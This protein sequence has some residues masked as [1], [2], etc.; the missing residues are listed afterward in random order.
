[1]ESLRREFADSFKSASKA[2][3]SSENF[4]LQPAPEATFR[5]LTEAGVPSSAITVVV[6]IR[7]QDEAHLAWYN[8][9][10]KAQGYTGSLEDSIGETLDLWD[11][12]RQL[13]PWADTFGAE[14]LVV[15][16]FN[17]PSL[18][19]GDIRHDFLELLGL[20]SN[21]FAFDQKPMNTGLNADLLAFQRELNR[22]PLS[23]QEKRLFHKDL[24]ELSGLTSGTGLFNDLPLLTAPRRQEI[25][26]RYEAGNKRLARRLG[27]ERLFEPLAIDDDTGGGVTGNPALSVNKLA[28]IVGWLLVRRERRS[29]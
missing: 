16:I 14:R 5:L 25:L 11:Y 12:D 24:M 1:L 4:Y 20:P 3:L 2:V 22:L 13:Q 17:L 23:P 29:E 18:K 15:R 21:H 6:Y 7:R 9:T 10:V 26:A 28:A 8:Q 19:N 27:R